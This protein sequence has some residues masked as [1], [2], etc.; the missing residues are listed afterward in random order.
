MRQSGNIFCLASAPSVSRLHFVSKRPARPFVASQKTRHHPPPTLWR[1][2]RSSKSETPASV[3]PG[4]HTADLRAAIGP[5]VH[6]QRPSALRKMRPGTASVTTDGR[7][8]RGSITTGEPAQPANYRHKLHMLSLAA[9]A[10]RTAAV[11]Q[12]MFRAY[13][14]APARWRNGSAP[15]S[16]T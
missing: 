11:P 8:A 3:R 6:S 13:A 14:S 12:R 2:G 7:D 4:Q 9:A 10:T 15:R 16:V 1:G 5:A